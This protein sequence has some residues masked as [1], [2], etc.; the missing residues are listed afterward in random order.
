MKLISFTRNIDSNP[1]RNRLDI[2][3]II[4]QANDYLIDRQYSFVQCAERIDKN[5]PFLYIEKMSRL[6]IPE[7]SADQ[8]QKLYS[9]VFPFSYNVEQNELSITQIAI[10]NSLNS[11]LKSLVNSFDKALPDSINK[12]QEYCLDACVDACED[13]VFSDVFYESVVTIFTRLLTF[14]VGYIRYDY[15]EMHCAGRIHPLHHLDIN[16]TNQST[17]KIGLNQSLDILEFQSIIDNQKERW[18]LHK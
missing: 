2:I 8:V 11:C 18:F 4:L 12:I 10:N 6:F 14:D 17:Y 9:I 16:Y 7:N 3:K 13:N 1:I 15:D 5:F